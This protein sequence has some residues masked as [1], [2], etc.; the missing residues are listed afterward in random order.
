MPN[1]DAIVVPEMS[2]YTTTG[3]VEPLPVCPRISVNEAAAGVRVAAT[4]TLFVKYFTGH[5]KVPCG[6]STTSGRVEGVL[7][8][9]LVVNAF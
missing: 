2:I 7:V 1:L 8:C 6:E 3:D 4:S 5:F 9:G